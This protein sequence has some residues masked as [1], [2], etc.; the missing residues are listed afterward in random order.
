MDPFGML[1]KYE[2]PVEMQDAERRRQAVAEVQSRKEAQIGLVKTKIAPLQKAL[3]DVELARREGRLK[4]KH[5]PK[6]STLYSN[7][8][9]VSWEIPMT[10]GV[11]S[12]RDGKLEHY[13]WLGLREPDSSATFDPG[14][15]RL[16]YTIDSAV[17]GKGRQRTQ[18]KTE[19]YISAEQALE[20]L[21]AILAT[22]RSY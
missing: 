1:R 2:N 13:I 11:F 7:Y 8:V 21:M 22:I 15:Y 19:F 5:G 3:E 18:D 12:K 17:R 4:F 6:I 20:A 10:V 14:P 16:N 9:S